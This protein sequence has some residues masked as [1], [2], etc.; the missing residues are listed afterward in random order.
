MRILLII[1]ALFAMPLSAEEQVTPDALFDLSGQLP[2]IDP[3]VER[4][5]LGLPKLD[6]LDLEI[7]AYAGVMSVEDFGANYTYGADF[8][9]HLT[10]DFFLAGKMGFSRINDRSFR[11]LNL[12]LFGK[13][14]KK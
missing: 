2:E 10:E 5:E 3:D 12:P 8:T 11:Q 6:S 1:L 14:G 13:S 9:F 7:G 4:R